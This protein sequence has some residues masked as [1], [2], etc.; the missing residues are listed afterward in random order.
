MDNKKP[1]PRKKKQRF[2]LKGQQA[3]IKEACE[4]VPKTNIIACSRCSHIVFHAIPQD[5]EYYISATS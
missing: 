1:K 3:F 5:E 2:D 4:T